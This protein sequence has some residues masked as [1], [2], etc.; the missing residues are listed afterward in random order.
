MSVLL[1]DCNREEIH[2]V[3]L[4]GLWP[5][6]EK[7]SEQKNATDLAHSELGDENRCKYSYCQYFPGCIR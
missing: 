4:L 5:K 3:I 2:F 7:L 6:L 1:F